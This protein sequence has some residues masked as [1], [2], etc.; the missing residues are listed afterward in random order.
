MVITLAVARRL[1]ETHDG[2][3]TAASP[4]LG[5][6]ATFEI[7]VPRLERPEL[8][9]LRIISLPGYGQS[10]DVRWSW[11]VGFDDYLTKPVDFEVLGRIPAGLGSSG[12]SVRGSA[13]VAAP[14]LAVNPVAA[15][16][17]RAPWERSPAVS[18]PPGISSPE[19]TAPPIRGR[20]ASRPRKA[21]SYRF[22]TARRAAHAGRRNP[23]LFVNSGNRL[24]LI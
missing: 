17:R 24:L 23:S 15:P 11:E 16:G 6:G 9:G 19:G 20:P 14:L 22:A 21:Q 3:L 5:Q 10:G 4:G 1:I 18:R 7:W 12:V 13:P 8:A 2:Q